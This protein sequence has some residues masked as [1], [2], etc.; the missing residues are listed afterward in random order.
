MKRI[1]VAR[2][3]IEAHLVK[4]LL[5]AE[6]IAVEVRGEA[7]FGA[8]GEIPMTEDTLPSIWVREPGAALRARGVLDA[9]RCES[10][11]GGGAVWRCPSCGEELEPQ[12][13]A[14]W[15]CCDDLG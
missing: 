14:C 8:R 15:R 7:L 3:P 5:E 13:S 2:D 10:P 9:F 11:L 12:F 1:Y 4:G 6:G